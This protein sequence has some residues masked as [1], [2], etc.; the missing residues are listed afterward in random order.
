MDSVN[1]MGLFIG[2]GVM[3]G[4]GLRDKKPS[5]EEGRMVVTLKEYHLTNGLE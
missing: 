2:Y 4:L 5:Y 1:E 3:V